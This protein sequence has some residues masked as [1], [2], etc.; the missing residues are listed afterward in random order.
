MARK[1]NP[2]PRKTFKSVKN[3]INIE[4]DHSYSQQNVAR[5]LRPLDLIRKPRCHYET[6]NQSVLPLRVT[7]QQ[8]NSQRRLTLPT[9]KCKDM[10][11]WHN[12]EAAHQM[13][14]HWRVVKE[15]GVITIT[16][17][18]CKVIPLRKD[19]MKLMSVVM[20]SPEDWGNRQKKKGI[21]QPEMKTKYKWQKGIPFMPI[22]SGKQR[23][24][25]GDLVKM[26]N[27]LLGR[28]QSEILPHLD[29]S[30]HRVKTKNLW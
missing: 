3:V 16:T 15:K 29:F 5:T 21:F 25:L 28:F 27:Y 22:N 26:K 4:L 17:I 2:Y 8:T 23:A 19:V 9:P 30:N 20:F 7:S 12:A 13:V 18:N 1:K 14:K 11:W 10:V 24:H 6:I